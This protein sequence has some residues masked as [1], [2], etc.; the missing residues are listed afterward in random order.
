[1]VAGAVCWGLGKS[2]H[3]EAMNN[4]NQNYGKAQSLQG[5]AQDYVTAGNAVFIAGGVLAALGTV[6]YFVG[7]SDSQPATSDAHT[8]LMPAVGPG[9]TGFNAGGTW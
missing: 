3:D 5:D 9:F 2:R 1:M 4:V 7:A 8:F 6:L